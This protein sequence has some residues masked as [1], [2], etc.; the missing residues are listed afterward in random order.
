MEKWVADN[1]QQLRNAAGNVELTERE[2]R[3]LEW[4]AGWE[5]GTVQTMCDIL[6]KA[7]QQQQAET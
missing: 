5:T 6:R 1:F 3:V 4:L 7:G 2:R